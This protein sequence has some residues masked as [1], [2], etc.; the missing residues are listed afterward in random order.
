MDNLLH[1]VA[2]YADIDTRRAMGF[3]PRKLPTSNLNLKLNFVPHGCAKKIHLGDAIS[4]T[5]HP[6]G[7]ISWGFRGP[8]FTSIT[9]YYFER[10]GRLRVDFV[11]V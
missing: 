8:R 3:A 10:D 4:L 7:G 9:E 1:H 5:V 2:K 6:R 11:Q